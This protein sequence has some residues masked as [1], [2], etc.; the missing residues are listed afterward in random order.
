MANGRSLYRS[1]TSRRHRHSVRSV[2]ATESTRSA[3]SLRARTGESAGTAQASFTKWGDVKAVDEY[4]AKRAV[5]VL[6]KK[7]VPPKEGA[8]EAPKG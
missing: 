4:W 3:A 1:R 8:P 6:L 7:G 5:I 2:Q